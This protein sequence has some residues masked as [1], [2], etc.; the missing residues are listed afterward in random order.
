[1]LV[2]EKAV[3]K[4][5][6]RRFETC[7][8]IRI[9]HGNDDEDSSSLDLRQSRKYSRFAIQNRSFFLDS[10]SWASFMLSLFCFCCFNFFFLVFRFFSIT[11]I[12]L[13][14]PSNFTENYINT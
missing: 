3:I 5:L 11:T 2:F 7:F 1:M 9:A 4:R 13:Y 12:T 8:R 10:A 6:F 14:P